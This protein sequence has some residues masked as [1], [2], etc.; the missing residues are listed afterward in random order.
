[1]SPTSAGDC[2]PLP[3]HDRVVAVVG[4]AIIFEGRCLV[5]RRTPEGS[6]GGKWE[7]PG[8]KVEPSESP[9]QALCREIQEELGTLIRVE[10][11]VGRGVASPDDRFLVLDVYRCALVGPR[12]D[13]PG[14]AHDAI[15][16]ATSD[17]LHG[18]NWALAD[19][20][21]VPRVA[22]LLSNSELVV[23]KDHTRD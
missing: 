14:A 19:V 4:A 10:G 11:W 7:F 21:I 9:E 13:V 12:I 22:A 20:P 3:S 6:S 8:G 17:D 18:L 16:W 1:M 2:P 15:L 5:A 23:T